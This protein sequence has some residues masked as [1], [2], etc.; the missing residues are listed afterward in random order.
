MPGEQYPGLLQA[1]L[2]SRHTRSPAIRGNRMNESCW[3]RWF[4]L[5]LPWTWLRIFVPEGWHNFS[6]AKR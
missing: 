3:R 4:I 6:R 2:I 5:S 1:M